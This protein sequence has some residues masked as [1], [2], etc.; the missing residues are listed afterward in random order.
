[1]ACLD[2]CHGA[3]A[4]GCVACKEGYVMSVEDG[5]EGEE[6]E[7]RRGWVRGEGE[8]RVGERGGRGEGG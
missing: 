5:C 1:M 2:G 7:E 4:K 8:E 6:G 3:G